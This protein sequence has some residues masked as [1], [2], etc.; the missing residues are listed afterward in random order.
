[1]EA[2]LMTS[3]D[4]MDQEVQSPG[5]SPGPPSSP[6][7]NSSVSWRTRAEERLVLGDPPCSRLSLGA[8]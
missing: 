3:L 4:S 8:T 6:P 1:M 7:V 5:A 2:G